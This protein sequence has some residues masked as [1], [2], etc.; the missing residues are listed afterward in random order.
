MTDM[1]YAPVLITTLNRYE[2]FKETITSL[3]QCT[4]ADMTDL[5]IA[6][7]YPPTPFY[8][9]GYRKIVEYLPTISG[10]KS[11]NIIKREK[12]YGMGKNF[13]DALHQVIFTKYDRF[14]FSE[15]DN[16]F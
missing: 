5:Y 9:D 13:H 7:D 2:H 3:S 1:I 12:N 6:L 11:V 14:I 4:G 15:D 10:F 8:E 16:L